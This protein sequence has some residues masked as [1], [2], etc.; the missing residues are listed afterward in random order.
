MLLVHAAGQ[1]LA[2]GPRAAPNSD[3]I[4]VEMMF[5]A[6]LRA[7]A[8]A[9]LRGRACLGCSSKTTA[10]SLNG[11]CL[12]RPALYQ[13]FGHS[14]VNAAELLRITFLVRRGVC[15]R[16]SVSPDCNP[17]TPSR[18]CNE[19]RAFGRLRFKVANNFVAPTV[20]CYSTAIENRTAGKGLGHASSC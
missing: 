8:E 10:P 4:D 15:G 11:T 7:S 9:H 17:L 14:M 19:P 1:W 18:P 5:H 13:C 12:A 16:L 2:W 3:L 6:G 20:G